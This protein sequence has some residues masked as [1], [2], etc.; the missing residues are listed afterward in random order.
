[1]RESIGSD[2]Y[3]QAQQRLTQRLSQIDKGEYID[4]PAKPATV[5][6]LYEGLRRH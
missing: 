5:A 2:D 3:K 4:R 1:M 6:E